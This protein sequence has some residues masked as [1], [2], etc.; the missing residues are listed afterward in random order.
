MDIIL[1]ET[2]ALFS[3]HNHM[4]DSIWI[5]ISDSGRGPGLMMEPVSSYHFN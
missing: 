3:P 4:S 5:L 2:S 1:G